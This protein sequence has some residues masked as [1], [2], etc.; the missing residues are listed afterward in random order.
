MIKPEVPPTTPNLKLKQDKLKNID[1]SYNSIAAILRKKDSL[2][3]NEEQFAASLT[4][5][6]SP[7]KVKKINKRKEKD[8]DTGK[9]N[10]REKDKEFSKEKEIN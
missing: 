1:L 4:Q 6:K 8:K 5:L 10:L 2:Q 9:D 3:E 7:P